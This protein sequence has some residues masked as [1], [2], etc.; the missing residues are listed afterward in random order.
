MKCDSVH[1]I[2]TTVTV[3]SR[4]WNLQGPDNYALQYAD[5]VQTYITESVSNAI[6]SFTST[7]ELT[8]FAVCWFGVECL[9]F[10]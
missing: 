4:R 9:S 8:V 2:D 10:N 3:W 6:L 1:V 5:G 7:E